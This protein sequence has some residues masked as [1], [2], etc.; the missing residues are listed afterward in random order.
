MKKFSVAMALTIPLVSFVSSEISLAAD[1]EPIV[2]QKAARHY[3]VVEE[4]GW[5]RCLSR[6]PD[7]YS[8][9]PLYDAYGPWGRLT[10]LLIETSLHATSGTAAVGCLPSKDEL[11]TDAYF[12]LPA[13]IDQIVEPTVSAQADAD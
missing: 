11:G 3:R 10:G 9:A 8:C 6:C 4:C 12:E 7:R 5:R 13:R 2:R 1:A